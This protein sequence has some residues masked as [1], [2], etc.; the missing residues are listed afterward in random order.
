MHLCVYEASY[1]RCSTAV[2][3]ADVA[4]SANYNPKALQ[5]DPEGNVNVHTGP[6]VTSFFG[7]LRRVHRIEVSAHYPDTPLFAPAYGAVQGWAGLYKG[8][9]ES[10]FILHFHRK[11][12]R[13]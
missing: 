6:V 2:T 10:A 11:F 7:M 5:L 12:T 8:F 1:L 9:S 3:P 4:K 13:T